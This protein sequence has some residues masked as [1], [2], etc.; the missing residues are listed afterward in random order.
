MLFR[1]TCPNHASFRLLTVLRKGSFGPTRK[2]ILLCTQS[3]VLCSEQEIQ[4]FPH[5]FGFKSLQGPCFTTVEGDEGDKRLMEF[6]LACKADGVAPP[7]FVSLAI[8]ETIRIR[9]S[10]EI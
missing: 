5:A 2:M 3:L 10:A 8:A 7:D 1:V 9:T 4:K 6:Q